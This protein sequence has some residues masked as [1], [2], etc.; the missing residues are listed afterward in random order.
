M[1]NKNIIAVAPA[2]EKVA[3]EVKVFEAPQMM[4]VE[5]ETVT[6]EDIVNECFDRPVVQRGYVWTEEQE[7]KLLETILAGKPIPAL[8]VGEL[9]VD[10]KNMSLIIDGLQRTT[11][12]RNL[13][14]H[15]PRWDE[16]T[17]YQR[18]EY[19]YLMEYTVHV[20]RIR[21]N[22]ILDLADL[23]TRYNSGTAL[24]AIQKGKAQLPADMLP[25]VNVWAEWA[26]KNLPAKCGSVNSDTVGT[27][28]ACAMSVPPEKI[29]TTGA[30]AVKALKACTPDAIP[31]IPDWAG[32]VMD[33]INAI[34][35][36]QVDY[37]AAYFV[38]PQRLLP[39]FAAIRD[40]KPDMA[41]LQD[42]LNNWELY[43]AKS[44]T[45]KLPSRGKGAPKTQRRSAS[46]VF[47]DR[48]SSAKANYQRYQM[49]C[50]FLAPQKEG[51]EEKQVADVA[52]LI[53]Q[54]LGGDDD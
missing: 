22:S 54:A 4:E 15:Y 40:C 49:V 30:P 35:P 25:K 20:M 6:A 1:E 33:A 42:V 51:K 13:S 44:F 23:F 47:G 18:N 50:K 28:L 3:E 21:C 39:L 29:A 31:G 7:D 5:F 27:L 16:M 53:G 2:E 24:T 36:E 19:S 8:I 37:N 32:D 43:L 45:I 14:T 46:A 41:I 11:A 26:Q 9:T 10:D 34:D 12:I 48:T 17:E 38:S 52:A